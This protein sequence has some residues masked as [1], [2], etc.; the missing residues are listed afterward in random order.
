MGLP[1]VGGGVIVAGARGVRCGPL[2][3]RRPL[4]PRAQ[5]MVQ[6]SPDMSGGR[7]CLLWR[8]VVKL[9]TFNLL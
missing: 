8:G 2:H 5:E 6:N 3:G 7:R 9:V 4:L 1:H